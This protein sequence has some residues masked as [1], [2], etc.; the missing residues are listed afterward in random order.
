MEEVTEKL[1]EFDTE[2]YMFRNATK[3]DLDKVAALYRDWVSEDVTRGLVAD[4]VDDLL[5]RLGPHFIVATHKDGS[6]VGFAIAEI[7]S[8]HICVFPRGENY[9]ILHDLY[10]TPDSRG[11]GIGSA[12]VDAILQSGRTCGIHRFTTYSANMA[13][14]PTLD[15]YHKRGFGMWSFSLFL[16][17]TLRSIE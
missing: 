1:T 8:E 6:I 7:S 17:G 13:W 12:L 3:N 4:T 9:L 2:T 15:F 10:V 14:Q 11:Q 16:D 5:C